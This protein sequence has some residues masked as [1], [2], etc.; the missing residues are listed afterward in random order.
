[1]L[2]PEIA[3][4]PQ[5]EAL[6]ERRFPSTHTVSLHSRLA[7]LERLEHWQA[8]RDGRARVVLGTRLAVFAPLPELG[9]SW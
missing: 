4:T 1:L 7:E 3:L 8:A 2:V 5:L 9:R 6:V